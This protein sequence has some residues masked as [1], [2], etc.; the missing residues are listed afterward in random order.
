MY[1][2]STLSVIEKEMVELWSELNDTQSSS[3][4]QRALN[5]WVWLCKALLMRG[6]PV[7]MD[8]VLKVSCCVM[9]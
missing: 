8:A 7:G 9:E 1:V 6:H 5:L 2:D 3:S 4:R